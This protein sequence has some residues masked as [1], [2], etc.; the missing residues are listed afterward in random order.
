MTNVKVLTLTNE[1]RTRVNAIRDA[2]E[3]KKRNIDDPSVRF[4]SGQR[5][6]VSNQNYKR[7]LVADNVY[8]D[9]ICNGEEFTLTYIRKYSETRGWHQHTLDRATLGLKKCKGE[10]VFFFFSM[11]GKRYCIEPG[12]VEESNVGPAWAITSNRAQGRKYEN[13]IVLLPQTLAETRCFY[14]N[15][16]HVMMTRTKRRSSS[17]VFSTSL[18]HS[19]RDAWI[20]ASLYLTL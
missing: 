19:R 7:K 14:R 12:F 18:K 17:S 2:M 1:A 5:L 9:A 8:S 10:H 11:E 3:L 4:Y 6:I 13:V 20:S 15:H 16:L